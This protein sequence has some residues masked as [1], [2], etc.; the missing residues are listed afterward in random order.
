MESNLN[1]SE[2]IYTAE[3]KQAMYDEWEAERINGRK[4]RAR[5]KGEGLGA[6]MARLAAQEAPPSK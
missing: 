6:M 3:Q 5:H 2:E 1:C 4:P